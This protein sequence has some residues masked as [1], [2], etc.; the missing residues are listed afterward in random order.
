MSQVFR[1]IVSWKTDFLE[2]SLQKLLTSLKK[3]ILWD[4]KV[5]WL[6]HSSFD[7]FAIYLK[8]YQTK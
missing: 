5:A 3:R 4:I 1:G 8:L 2:K 7:S 6:H